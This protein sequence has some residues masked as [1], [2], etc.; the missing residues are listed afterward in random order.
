MIVSRLLLE[1]RHLRL[2]LLLERLD[3]QI[4][5]AGTSQKINAHHQFGKSIPGLLAF[6]PL[7]TD[8]R[9]CDRV[10]QM[11]LPLK[12]IK[13][14]SGQS[15]LWWYQSDCNI[16]PYKPCIPLSTQPK[17]NSRFETQ[18]NKSNRQNKLFPNFHPK[19]SFPPPASAHFMQS[20]P[21]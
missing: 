8:G 18:M 13:Y 19:R 2:D 17:G 6:I 16:P 15:G 10:A 1:R 12:S 21:S 3:L 14:P 11:N 9:W 4:W 7:I 5:L 20:F